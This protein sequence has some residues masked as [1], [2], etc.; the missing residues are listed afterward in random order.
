MSTEKIPVPGAELTDTYAVPR[1]INGTWQLSEGHS[2]LPIADSLDLF[3]KLIDAGLTAFDCADIY[4]GVEALLGKCL[5]AA[6]GRPGRGR[7]PIHIH[8]KCV[9]DLQSLPTLTPEDITSIVHRSRIRLGVAQLDLVQLHWWD[10]DI[11]GIVEAGLTLSRLRQQGVIRNIGVTNFD[12]PHL[13]LLLDAGVPVVSNQVQFSLLDRRPENA[14]LSLCDRHGISLLCYGTVAGGF[15]SD[16][17]LDQPDPLIPLENRSLVKYRLII[18]EFGGWARF[19]KLLRTLR[20]IADKHHA[21]IATVATRYIL[22]KPSVAA[23]IVGTRRPDHIPDTVRVFS[24]ALD[25][26][27]LT[28]IESVSANAGLKGPIYGLERTP[29]S[30]HASIMHTNLCQGATDPDETR[31]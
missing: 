7:V 29:D 14:M 10:F 11:P 19:Q 8:T 30:R 6:R 28:R 13:Q 25:E 31:S 24:F 20:T 5:C 18:D 4:T 9:P 21:S 3:E 12:A 2:R 15:L 26:E 17:Y 22:Q 23:A 27:D 1:I 16:R